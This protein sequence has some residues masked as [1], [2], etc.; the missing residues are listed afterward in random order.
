[1]RSVAFGRG[2]APAKP[3]REQAAF[4]AWLNETLS[5]ADGAE[6]MR[7][8]VSWGKEAPGFRT[9]HPREEHIM[10]LIPVVA[11]ATE[12]LTIDACGRISIAR[13]ARGDDPMA[14]GDGSG[15]GG[16]SSA[17]VEG[18]VAVGADGAVRSAAAGG[19]GGTA[20][21]EDGRVARSP[22]VRVI[23][24]AWALGTM[25]QHSYLFP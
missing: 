10:P 11:A 22:P 14:G 3:D 23:H 1:M 5:L 7:R 8:L 6:R 25:A 21:G 20:A 12:G 18:K 2:G 17:V 13:E 19:G 15:G 16:G 4:V 24:E 9:A